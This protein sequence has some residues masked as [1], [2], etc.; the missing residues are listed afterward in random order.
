MEDPRLGVKKELHLSATDTWDPSCV[1][2][3]HHSSRQCWILNPLSKARD[4]IQVLMDTSWVR[5]CSATTASLVLLFNSYIITMTWL[6]LSLFN[7]SPNLWAFYISISFH[8][9]RR[10][11]LFK[12]VQTRWLKCSGSVNRLRK[13]ML[14]A[15]LFF[16][17]PLFFRPRP[18][19]YGSSQASGWTGAASTAYATATATQNLSHICHLHHSS[20]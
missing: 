6:Y 16:F 8:S 13:Q 3:L 14:C 7:K 15:I 4:W 2:D 5:Y 19:A 10:I 12:G 1:C 11:L 17:F 9:S 18:A 20:Q